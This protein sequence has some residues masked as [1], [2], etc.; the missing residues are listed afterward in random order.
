MIHLDLVNLINLSEAYVKLNLEVVLHEM[1]V[2]HIEY[3]YDNK[4][5]KKILAF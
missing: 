5:F 3:R 2:V 1:Y 4:V